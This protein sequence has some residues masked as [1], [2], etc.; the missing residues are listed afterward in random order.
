MGL[1]SRA[2]SR[3]K[4][5]LYLPSTSGPS[6]GQIL[7]SSIDGKTINYIR[8]DN[9][10]FNSDIFSVMNRISSDIASAKFKTASDYASTLLNSPS[11]V[12]SRF[13]FWQSVILQLLADGNAYV[14]IDG[15]RLFQRKPSDVSI[16]VVGNQQ[17]IVYTF[18]PYNG[19]QK[20]VLD[21]SQVLH[22]RLM[23]SQQYDYLI[24]MSPLESLKYEMTI[25]T[26][27]K[28]ATL[29]QV[30]NQISPIGVLTLQAS[31]L[32][33]DDTETA[34]KAFEK[35]NS[36]QN[37]GR[38]MVL[39]DGESYSQL[40]VKADVFSALTKNADY[41][42]SQISKAFGIPVDMLGGGKSTESAHSNI[43]SVKGNYISDLNS[44]INP[45]LDELRLKLGAPDLKLDVKS[46][47]D[48]DDSLIVGQINSLLQSGAIDV[49]QAQAMLRQNG[50]ITNNI[51][52]FEGGDK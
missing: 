7:Q 25:A 40:D 34:R 29:N 26:K 1:L 51:P 45:I 50:V 44:Y 23:P 35:M 13:S 32:S 22:F 9:A 24:G 39:H 14:K 3:F 38:L 52:Q 36:G 2:R 8:A 33:D 41:S 31:V 47:L 17:H 27:S 15:L 37:R 28:E 49:G 12:L 6:I 43:D 4:N 16:T 30:N 48:V 46:A 5:D 21:E 18:L 42:A 20:E 10:L 11:N 19:G